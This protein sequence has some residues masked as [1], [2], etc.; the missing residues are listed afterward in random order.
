MKSMNEY[1]AII[2]SA[3]TAN[4]GREYYLSESFLFINKLMNEKHH[5]ESAK[6]KMMG[7]AVRCLSMLGNYSNADVF[8]VNIRR[9]YLDAWKKGEIKR[10]TSVAF[11]KLRQLNPKLDKM[12]REYAEYITNSRTS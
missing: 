1:L 7:E 6:I 5:S 10:Y 2:K 9:A 4:F 12:V 3:Q 8:K 11:F